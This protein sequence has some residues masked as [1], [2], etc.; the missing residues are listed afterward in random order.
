MM[1]PWIKR[2]TAWAAIGM[3]QS[4]N[5]ELRSALKNANADLRRYK[6]LLADLRTDPE[7]TLKRINDD[8][9]GEPSAA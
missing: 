4:E 3:V 2:S 9:H 1:W 8:H 7:V 6:A 5:R